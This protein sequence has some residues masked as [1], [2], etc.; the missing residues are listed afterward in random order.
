VGFGRDMF[1]FIGLGALK[2]ALFICLIGVFNADFA[3]FWTWLG[4]FNAF[5][6]IIEGGLIYFYDSILNIVYLSIS[7]KI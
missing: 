3:L 4:D 1:A 7:Y 6:A 5:L 2:V